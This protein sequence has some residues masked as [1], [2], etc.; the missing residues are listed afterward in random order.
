MTPKTGFSWGSGADA[1]SDVANFPVGGLAGASL[2]GGLR[3]V[4]QTGTGA[5]KAG[6]A[7][8][9]SGSYTPPAWRG[10]RV[11]YNGDLATDR[12]LR[13][14][15]A[16]T[17]NVLVPAAPG[18]ADVKVHAHPQPTGAA[19]T[20]TPG[21]ARGYDVGETIRATVTFSYPVAV[22]GTPRLA[23]SVGGQTRY[24]GYASRS[25]DKHTLTFEYTVVLNDEDGD[26]GRHRDG[27]AGPERREHRARRG[28]RRR[29]RC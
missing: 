15:F 20:S 16:R 8:P 21:A 22:G 12:T 25:A 19:L 29:R 7:R 1:G 10:V 17:S 28:W 27:G 2:A 11:A 5:L 13:I 18:W 3:P 9:A 23:L 4:C 6:C 24:A 14:S 26:G